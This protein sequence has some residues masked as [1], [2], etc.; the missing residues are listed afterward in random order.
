MSQ[1]SIDQTMVELVIEHGSPEPNGKTILNRKSLLALC[2]SI[3]TLKKQIVR[4]LDKGG[5]VVVEDAGTLITTYRLDS[6]DHRRCA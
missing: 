4:A 3:N 6:F 5:L 2:E 1:R